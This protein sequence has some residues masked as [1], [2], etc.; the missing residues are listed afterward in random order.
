MDPDDDGGLRQRSDTEIDAAI[1]DFETMIDKAN[2]V[3]VARR[4]M[5]IAMLQPADEKLRTQLRI[6]LRF[7]RHCPRHWATS[8]GSLDSSTKRRPT[9]ANPWKFAGSCGEQNTPTSPTTWT[10]SRSY[11]PSKVEI[12]QAEALW[13]QSLD[14]CETIKADSVRAN[15]LN[16]SGDLLRR[17]GQYDA[18]EELLVKS[19]RAKRA[20]YNEEHQQ[21]AHCLHDLAQLAKDRGDSVRQ[22]V[23]RTRSTGDVS[24]RAR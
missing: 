18:A 19:L 17:R 2:P 4:C 23:A 10:N 24:P 9:C 20:L 15:I 5:D 8:I 12:D 13:A 21:I 3:N 14:I 22:R 1:A 16:H 7:R 6:N 11:W